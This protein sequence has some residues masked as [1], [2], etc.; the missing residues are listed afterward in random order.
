LNRAVSKT[1]VPVTPVPRVRIPPPPLQQRISRVLLG[2]WPWAGSEPAAAQ[3]PTSVS[4]R[5]YWRRFIPRHSPGRHRGQPG[6]CHGSATRGGERCS[7]AIWPAALLA[8]VRSAA[9]PP[10][11]AKNVRVARHRRPATGSGWRHCPGAVVI[12]PAGGPGSN[13]GVPIAGKPA[14][15][16]GFRCFRARL[17]VRVRP[18]VLHLDQVPQTA[19]GPAGGPGPIRGDRGGV[20]G[21]ASTTPQIPIRVPPWGSQLLEWVGTTA[22]S[23]PR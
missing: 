17:E 13:P 6:E 16:R 7:R 11:Q 22:K 5:P 1:V 19:A 8:H 23:V 9:K 20:R 21:S 3:A 18:H 12:A 14:P 10:A 15:G 4:G 2:I